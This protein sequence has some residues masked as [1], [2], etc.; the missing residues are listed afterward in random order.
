MIQIDREID[1]QKEMDR[2]ILPSK[3][4]VPDIVIVVFP[5][6]GP[7]PGTILKIVGGSSSIRKRKR[8]RMRIRLADIHQTDAL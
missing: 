1:R 3:K 4:L 7:P 6:I 2:L 5:D 8:K